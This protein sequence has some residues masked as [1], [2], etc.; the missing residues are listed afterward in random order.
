L[1]FT[2][3]NVETNQFKVKKHFL[4]LIILSFVL[5]VPAMAQIQDRLDKEY[6]L[7]DF[8]KLSHDA[9]EGRKT[10]TKG[11]EAARRFI[12]RQFS[13]M[14]AKSLNKGYRHPFSFVNSQ[15]DTIQGENV[16]AY[17]KG[18]QQKAIVITA[19]YDHLG[20]VD[21]K[22]YNGADD[23]ASGVAAM[24]AMAEYFK[25]HKPNHTIVFAA[26]DAE[27]MG[28]RGA[29]AFVEDEAIPMDMVILNVNMD[30]ISVND[31]N[32]LY[33]A[34]THHHPN[35]K[36]ILEGVRT[37]PLRLRFGH[38]S[39]DLGKDDWTNASDHAAFHA[40]GIPFVYFGV[41]DHENYHKD[42]DTFENINE[43]FYLKSAEAILSCILALDR[44]LN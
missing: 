21:D 28:L 6:M 20:I 29:R 17:I 13:T 2:Q 9:A 31:K 35:F 24:M 18:R 15:N 11:A 4:T 36:P 19:H 30:M 39:P 23:N 14:K 40:K 44:S 26:L 32:E 33:V 43:S 7:E 5:S 12:I 22:I 3:P 10:G 37:A 34:G 1:A 41:E 16:V 25:R 27:E 38:D 8:R 42:T